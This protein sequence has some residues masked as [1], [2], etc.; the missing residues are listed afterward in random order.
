MASLSSGTS[1]QSVGSGA[2]QVSDDDDDDDRRRRRKT[3]VFKFKIVKR[4]SST[5]DSTMPEL[6]VFNSGD[7][8]T[9]STT[10]AV[11][12]PRLDAAELTALAVVAQAFY[13]MSEPAD[14]ENAS[15]SSKPQATSPFALFF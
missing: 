4:R 13:V 14:F 9:R 10:S 2:G 12:A 5:A 8:D 3:R 7:E 11:V 15:C 6:F 1:S